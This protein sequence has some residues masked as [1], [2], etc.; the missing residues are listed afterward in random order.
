MSKT[1]YL[2]KTLQKKSY[3]NNIYFLFLTFNIH[4]K[5]FIIVPAIILILEIIFYILFLNPNFR[6]FSANLCTSFSTF[7]GSPTFRNFTET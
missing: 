2:L 6:T 3:L 7:S 1:I 5:T 4:N